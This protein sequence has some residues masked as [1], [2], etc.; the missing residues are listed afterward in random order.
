MT[1]GVTG[2]GQRRGRT[3]TC[4]RGDG[5]GARAGPADR[6]RV[7]VVGAGTR[8][9]PDPDPPM[10]NGRAIAVLAAREGA[11]VACADRDRQAA[12]ETAGLVRAEGAQAEVVVADVADA[13]ACAQRGRRSRRPLSAD[14]TAWCSTSASASAAA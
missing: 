6:R 8:P 4:R 3:P 10:G 9:S 14:S 1:A 5:H 2:G 13:A 7:L 11:A 12:E